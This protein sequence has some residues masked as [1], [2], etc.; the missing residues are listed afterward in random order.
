MHKTTEKSIQRDQSRSEELANSLSHGIGLLAAL[1]ATPYLISH[2]G[3]RGDAIFVFATSLFAF[4]I[5]L[6]YLGSTL[7]HALRT[8][9]AKRVFQIIE[10][11]AIYLLIAGTYSPL[12]LGVLRGAW[13]W[14]MFG[15]VWGLAVAG[16]ALKALGK[17]S[18][19]LISTT[20]YVLMGWIIVIAAKPLLTMTPIPGLLWLVAGGLA[21]TTGVAFYSNDYRLR[22]GHLIW[23]FFVLAGT[24]CHY[25]AVLW[26]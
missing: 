20:L 15:V 17:A 5:V 11:S 19:P 13:G 3:R 1:A 25:F 8:G 14:S 24:T 2:A 21:Y 12:T 7:Y 6:L 18:H 26:F 10:H 22:Y 23:H 4:T 16:V 9:K